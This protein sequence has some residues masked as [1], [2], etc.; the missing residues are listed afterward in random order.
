MTFM[1]NKQN[2]LK[3]DEEEKR[4]L[5]DCEG[6]FS[7]QSLLQKEFNQIEEKPQDREKKKIKW[8]FYLN[9]SGTF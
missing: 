9:L 5:S 3:I 6:D 8:R 2:G 1:F 4:L 7:Q